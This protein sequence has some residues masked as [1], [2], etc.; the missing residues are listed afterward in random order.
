MNTGWLITA[1]LVHLW[2]GVYIAY[3]SRQVA[4][5]WEEKYP[6]GGAFIADIIVWSRFLLYPSS[7]MSRIEGGSEL[8]GAVSA[9]FRKKP[10]YVILHLLGWEFRMAANFLVI[11]IVILTGIIAGLIHCVVFTAKNVIKKQ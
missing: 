7:S 2:I 1:I 6:H 10:L 11:F 5:R 9:D 3:L 4:S 8:N